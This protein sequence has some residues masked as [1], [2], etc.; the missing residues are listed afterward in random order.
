MVWENSPVQLHISDIWLELWRKEN[1]IL[2]CGPPAGGQ[3]RS[4]PFAACKFLSFKPSKSFPLISL[5]NVMSF[6]IPVSSDHS[7][8]LCS[9]DYSAAEAFEELACLLLNV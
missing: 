3:N 6:L 1:V 9:M 5:G 4:G 2:H 8:A 7:E